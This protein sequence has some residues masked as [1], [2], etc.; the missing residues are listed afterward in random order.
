MR[1]LRLVRDIQLEG[2][3]AGQLERVEKGDGRGVD[4]QTLA[5]KKL[6][7]SKGAG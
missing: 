5:S 1:E 3:S 6:P 2:D 7:P 4:Y